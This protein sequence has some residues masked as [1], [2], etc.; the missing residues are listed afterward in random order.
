L[1]LP[2]P[3]LGIPSLVLAWRESWIIDALLVF[4]LRMRVV[5]MRVL[6]ILFIFSRWWLRWDLLSFSLDSYSWFCACVPQLWLVR[7]WT[8]RI[9]NNP[10]SISFINIL[11]E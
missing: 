4:P 11:I 9:Q 1:L 5:S 8:R 7:H 2:I 6:T 3:F 10:F